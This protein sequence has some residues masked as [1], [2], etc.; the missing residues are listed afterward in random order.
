ME[1]ERLQP[2]GEQLS[3]NLAIANRTY[4]QETIQ[5]VSE[6]FDE[7]HRRALVVMATGTGKTRTIMALIEVFLRAN[8]LRRM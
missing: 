4:Q 6:R 1:S 5:E 2:G 8:Q 3:V 7:G